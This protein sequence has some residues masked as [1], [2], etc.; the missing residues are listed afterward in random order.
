[1]QRNMD[2]IRQL[3]LGLEG[4]AS[5]QYEFSMENVDELEKW[6]N[7]DLLVQANLIRGLKV[8]WAADGTGPYP[9]TKGLVALTW[10][11]HD[12]LDAVRND[13]VWHR[14]NE[15]AKAGGLDMQSLTFEVIKSLCVSTAKHV[16]GL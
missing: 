5:T 8:R 14:A 4:E 1:M 10:E 9:H 15:K 13:S 2:L 3:L 6:Y 11:G 16:M 7:V 12:F